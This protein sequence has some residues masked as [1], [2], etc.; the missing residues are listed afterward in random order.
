MSN[1]EINKDMLTAARALAQDNYDTWGARIIEGFTD[2]VLSA[3]LQRYTCLAHWAIEQS[4][5]H[6]E[7]EYL[8]QQDS[9]WE[10]DEGIE[11]DREVYRRMI[12]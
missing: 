3:N 11:T 12:E 4:K 7:R 8:V 2:Q 9:P 6:Q 10:D 1:I 5:L